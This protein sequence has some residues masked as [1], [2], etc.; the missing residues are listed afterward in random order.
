[1]KDQRIAKTGRWALFAALASVVMSPVREAQ[2]SDAEEV[3][4]IV[5]VPVPEDVLLEVG[6]LAMMPNG[7]LG[8]ATRRGEIFIVK[9]PLSERPGFEQFAFGMHEVLGL[10]F[11][12][13]AFYAVQRGELTKVADTDGDGRAD[14]YETVYAWPLSGNYHEYSYGPKVAPDGRFF[15][16]TNLGFA[17][18]EWWRGVSS[19]PWRGW[20]MKIAPDGQMEPWAT[21]MRSPAGLAVID[22]DFFYSDNQGDWIGSGGIWHL[23]QGTFAGHPGGLVWS[24][25]P[26]APIELAQQQIFEQVD[27]R[28]LRDENGKYIKPENIMNEAGFKTLADVAAVYPEVRTPAVWLPHGILGT[29]TS[30]VVKIPAGTFGPFSGQLLVGD[31]GQSKL[32]RVFLEEVDGEFQGAAFDFRAGFKSGVFRLAF[33]GDGSLFVGMTS[34]GWRSVGPEMQG[35]ERLVYNGEIPFEMKAVRAMP[36]GF[37]IEFTKPVEREGAEDLASYAGQSFTYKYHSVYG[38]PPVNIEELDIRG[39]RVSKDG[40]RVRLVVDGLRRHYVHQLILEGIRSEEQDSPLVHGAAYYTLRNIP[41]GRRL[42]MR[43]LSTRDS[44]PETGTEPEADDLENLTD[45][46]PLLAKNTC[47]ACHSADRRKVGPAFAEIAARNYSVDKLVQL[48]QQPENRN[49]PEFSTPMPPMA[50]VPKAEVRQIATWINSL[51]TREEKGE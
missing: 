2:A 9:D 7:D 25:E 44:T 11:K 10:A 37:E 38:S 27:E 8:A 1:M 14:L 51:A 22:G 30:D 18:P 31:Q 32:A 24:D 12:D 34:R 36:D 5:D 19:V 16:T 49:W 15:V 33:A 4:R 28:R 23:P 45:V 50:H 20:A 48:I 42:A 40:Y 41:A 21:G 3:F 6:G 35:L 13:G 17:S 29:S 47:T 43:E 46:Q 26:D 39:V